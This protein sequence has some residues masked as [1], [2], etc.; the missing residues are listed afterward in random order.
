MKMTKLVIIS[1]VLICISI[2][3]GFAN[4]AEQKNMWGPSN[5]GLQ[6]GIAFDNPKPSFNQGE[7]V[8]ISI[9][10]RNVSNNPILL[11]YKENPLKQCA[12]DVHVRDMNSVPV[13]SP[14]MNMRG[15]LFNPTLNPG[16]TMLYDKK[17][18]VMHDVGWEG[19]VDN[20]IV[21]AG[22]G[23]YTLSFTFKIESGF[24]SPMLNA[25]IWQ[26][27]LT[28]GALDLQ[29]EPDKKTSVNE[30]IK[31]FSQSDIASVLNILCVYTS[32]GLFGISVS[33]NGDLWKQRRNNW[34]LQCA[35]FNE[36]AIDY[37][38]HVAVE[39]PDKN[40]RAIACEAAGY[41]KNKKFVPVLE[42]CLTD[43]FPEIRRKSAR[44]LGDL[45]SLDSIPKIS[46]LL[47]DN[48]DSV[49]SGAAAAL[50][51]MASRRATSALVEAF[52]KEKV[53]NIKDNMCLS[54]GWIA[55]PAALPALKK[56]LNGVTGSLQTTLKNVIR[57]I[58]DPDYWGLGVKGEI[59]AKDLCR[60]LFEKIDVS[61]KPADATEAKA[62]LSKGPDRWPVAFQNGNEIV[63]YI[64]DKNVFYIRR[65]RTRDMNEDLYFGPFDGNPHD[66]V[67]PARKALEA[68]IAK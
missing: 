10:I 67:R 55:D 29:V 39:H 32:Q 68:S 53:I 3:A 12:P 49:R 18:L 54:L 31:K 27:E 2:Q 25:G 19:A 35:A 66:I 9:S 8:V 33:G 11:N 61:S 34:E 15:R 40:Y 28:T 63:Y 60:F 20:S 38:A 4:Q 22:S 62:L 41:T 36:G 65:N 57:N 44:S 24:S 37:L 23:K 13:M 51:N 50:G 16:Q 5:A 43:S 17:T 45:H 30:T 6:A 48:E 56:E 47:R 1:G 64:A 42:I 14:S 46:L 58:E 26:G 59:S 7:P 52:E 21:F